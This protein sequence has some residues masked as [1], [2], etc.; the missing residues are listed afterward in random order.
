MHI[1]NFFFLLFIPQKVKK[2]GRFHYDL[3]EVRMWES[4]RTLAPATE[5]H[6][7]ALR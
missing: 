1:N 5:L 6:K 2:S 4:T 3:T 7:G